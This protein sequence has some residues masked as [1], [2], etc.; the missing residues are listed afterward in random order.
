I[1][2]ETVQP[3][4][5]DYTDAE[6]PSFEAQALSYSETLYRTALRLTGHPQDAEDLV[7]ETFLR[8]FRCVAQFTPG[9]NL[10]AWLVRILT[11]SH[12]DNCRAAARGPRLVSLE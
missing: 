4:A 11:N 2:T 7:Q 5:R 3:A 8:A 9:T 12:V 6:S 10:R 1:L